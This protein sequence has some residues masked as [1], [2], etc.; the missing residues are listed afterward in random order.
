MKIENWTRLHRYAKRCGQELKINLMPKLSYQKLPLYL[1][2]AVFI[3]GVILWLG[4]FQGKLPTLQETLKSVGAPGQEI[5]KSLAGEDSLTLQKTQN[6]F[7]IQ[8][9]FS[10][11]TTDNLTL[12]FPSKYGDK[13]S[14]TFAPGQTIS[15]LDKN[16]KNIAGQLLSNQTNQKNPAYVEYSVDQRKTVFYAYQKKAQTSVLKNWILY[17]TPQAKEAESY[18]FEN[19][20]LT[21]DNN[22]NI[23]VSYDD[24]KTSTL[25]SANFQIPRP[26]FIDKD[27]NRNDLNWT[28]EK[29]TLSIEFQA[30]P[31]KYPLVLDPTL[32]F[33]PSATNAAWQSTPTSNTSTTLADY[34]TTP[35]TAGNY[36]STATDDTDYG[37]TTASYPTYVDDVFSA[38][39][40]TGNGAT[41]TINNGIDLAGKGGMVWSK[42]RS[43][44][45]GGSNAV[46][47]TARG[48]GVAIYTNSTT[49]NTSNTNGLTS[50]G[51]GGYSLG[52]D[53]SGN[54][55]TASDNYVSWT[56]RKA[57]KFFDVVTYTGDGTPDRYINH[58]LGIIPGMVM[59][60]AVS[61]TSNWVVQVPPYSQ[62]KRLLLNTTAAELDGF[63]V[64]GTTSTQFR[65]L[66]TTNGTY[67]PYNTNTLGVTYVAYIFADDSSVNGIIRC[68]SAIGNAAVTLG[69]EPQ[70]VLAKS[71][72]SVDQWYVVDSSR[73]FP[74]YPPALD[75]ELAPN[76]GASENTINDV[77]SPNATGF[78]FTGLGGAGTNIYCAIRR[79]NK[80]P[81]SGTQ[82]YNAIARTGTGAAAT[83]TGVGFA[84]DLVIDQPRTSAGVY[85]GGEFTDRL[86]GNTKMLF[87][88]GTQAEGNFTDTVTSFDMGGISIGANAS[89]LGINP[90]G[91][92]IINHFF[93][94]APGV[95]DE[96]AYTGT[97][98][99]TTLAHNLGVEPELMIVKTR[100]YTWPWTVY[101]T[102]LGGLKG[103]TLNDNSSVLSDSSYWN[104]LSPT[105]SVINL[106]VSA[107]TNASSS[108]NYIA[109]LFATKPGISKVGSYTG[110]GTS[111]TLNAGFTGGAKFIMIKRTDTTGDWFVWDT[112]RGITNGSNDPHLSLNST[113]AEV[114][115]DNSIDPAN[116]GFIVNQ[117]ATTNINV[118]GGTY[119]YL[120]FSGDTIA[121]SGATYASNLYTFDL[122]SSPNPAKLHF[123]L[124]AFATAAAGNGT[125]AKIWNN[126]S[127]AWET[128]ATL[129]NTASSMPG[130]ASSQEITSNLSNYLDGSH[131][132]K[133]L[134]SSV[135]PSSSSADAVL[136]V[137]YLNL[138]TTIPSTVTSITPNTATN[139]NQTVSGIAIGGT[140][141]A[142]GATVTFKKSGQPD[143]PC[144]SVNV[145]STTALTCSANFRGAIAGTWNVQVTNADG[146]IGTLSNGLTITESTHAQFTMVGSNNVRGSVNLVTSGTR[147]AEMPWNTAP[148]TVSGTVATGQT[149]TCSPGSWGGDATIS[150]TYQWQHTS[151]NIPSATASTYVVS[152]S[153]V[154]ET[155]KCVVTAS[156]GQGSA[157]AS[158]NNA[159]NVCVGVSSIVGAGGITY[160]TVVGADGKCWLDRNL[161][162]PNVATG[163]AD[164]TNYGYLYQWGRNT[165]GHQITTSSTSSTLSPTD[166]VASPD[167]TK[168]I[169]APSS[170]YDWRSGQNNALWQGVSGT[171]NPCPTGFRIPTQPE[172]AAWVT[173]AGITNY[174]T[175][176]SSNLKL[177]AAGYRDYGGGTLYLRGAY[178]YYWSSS[179]T[180]IFAFNLK[181]NSGGVNP[182]DNYYRAYGF[183]VRCV[184]D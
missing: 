33:A 27:G 3:T 4:F 133:L 143:I 77:V 95:F 63:G 85:Y 68:G 86:R 24:Q 139:A 21:Q 28:I 120:A 59:I 11:K 167:T 155:L 38:Y 36:T 184:K 153:Y 35:F 18:Q 176:F 20:R 10:Q 162:A 15:I 71:A 154:G 150:Y 114:T 178:G 136:S 32:N 99:A 157:V 108:Y 2:S 160:G 96:V 144:T 72:T 135:N 80:P 46:V 70:Y 115:T 110:N 78:K 31:E 53:S 44:T 51:S 145:S 73:G 79:P 50:F 56:F 54:Y 81:T 87:S 94:R 173:A 141:F 40:Y 64:A 164:S 152:A 124:T 146:G 106:G 137:D 163:Y 158:S 100:N 121:D 60:K 131:K 62:S 151:T 116:S 123:D 75:N 91:I 12:T 58:S 127:S 122:T 168:F 118:N 19:A 138:T 130:S 101:H 49:N 92:N 181:F 169:L 82:V 129:S 67:S 159:F 47:D 102:F 175:A 74:V 113:T 42:W 142:A 43:G 166:A 66:Y 39:T 180:G 26:F 69:W 149:L 9:S 111:Q 25:S 88:T 98:S 132:V 65:T 182:A 52:A 41:Q 34:Q 156:N 93:R 117:N 128:L 109:Y 1:L 165:D 8:D 76:S 183:S 14:A 105:A 13:I 5:L 29:D 171:N 125:I 134:V 126:N 177:T 61:T 22:G 147:T 104:S 17:K 97:G 103:L 7:Q 30:A 89:V 174:I 84:P 6:G 112:T 90:N 16:A 172:W 140:N 119:I 170:P 148:P 107:R 55:N 37:V 45:G 48:A 83:V 23:N 57:P 161:G 179:V